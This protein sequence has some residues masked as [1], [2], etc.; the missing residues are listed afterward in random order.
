MECKEAL[1]HVLFLRTLPDTTIAEIAG[2]GTVH[3]L[4]KGETLFLEKSRCLGLIV[5]LSG[6]VRVYK[7]D[8]RGRELT[9]DL[10]TP[11]RSV[12]E[13]PLFDGGNYP[14]NAE[15]AEEDTSIFVVPQ[16]RFRPIMARCPEITE[17]GLK[18]LGIRM[19]KLMQ[20]LEAQALYPVRAR[21]AD[22]LLRAAQGRASFRLAETNEA[23][24]SQIGTVREVVSRTLRHLAV[25]G[26]IALEGR[27]VTI[28]E[29]ELLRRMAGSTEEEASESY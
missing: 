28:R 14:A 17:Q 12:G 22:Y 24:G 19:R 6:A 1:R 5:V 8:S 21:L 13:M 29:P 25:I 26:A 16:E 18:A 9:L 2:K 7:L 3:R 27:Q 15:A 4:R 11:G 20:M 23:I 10:E